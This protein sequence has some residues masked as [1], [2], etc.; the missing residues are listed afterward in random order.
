MADAAIRDLDL[1][2]ARPGARRAMAMG[3]S[4]LSAAWAP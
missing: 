4:G 3:S 2:V 1:H